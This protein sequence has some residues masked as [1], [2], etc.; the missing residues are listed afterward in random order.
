[1]K[2][3]AKISVAAVCTMIIISS[4]NDND[5][6]SPYAEIYSKPAFAA[7][8]DSIKKD[9]KNPALLFRRA[10]LL[11]S[12]NFPEP[13]LADFRQA[14]ALQKEEKYALGIST[15][16]LEKQPEAALQFLEN[17]L[18][19]IPE[20]YLLRLSMARAYT[21]NGKFKEAL[22]ACDEM[23]SRN[24]QLP[25][26]IKLKA[27]L[28]DKEN[29]TAAATQLWEQAYQLAPF[30]VELNYILALRYAEAKDPRVLTICDSLIKADTEGRHAEPYYYKGIYYSNLND[31]T[32]A[33]AFF[34]EAIRHDY[35]FLDSYI[36]KGSL[37]YEQKKYQEAL[38]V[39]NLALTISP[40]F[41]DSYYWIAKCQEATGKKEEAK[42]N[43][44]RAF[45]LD[46]TMMEAKEAAARMGDSR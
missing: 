41:A 39:F 4:C 14:W 21:A 19:Q 5:S 27:D 28:L 3:F 31:K 34:D 35:Y 1:M 18:K 40:S 29:K 42:I 22:Q 2:Y 6:E 36:E 9:P 46:K 8:S 24:P 17:A 13:A 15:L 38:A 12:N 45:E 30:D 16:L 11:N 33:L 20:S 10:V 32:K 23:L 25:D 44:L 37:F 26:V 7:I 43:Y